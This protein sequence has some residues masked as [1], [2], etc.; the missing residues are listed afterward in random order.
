MR[1]TVKAMLSLHS[2]AE[3]RFLVWVMPW[4]NTLARVVCYADA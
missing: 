1:S 2:S 4:H 3:I